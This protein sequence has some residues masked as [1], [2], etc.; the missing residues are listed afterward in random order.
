MYGFLQV[1]LIRNNRHFVV[2]LPEPDVQTQVA[3]GPTVSAR[4]PNPAQDVERQR[5]SELNAAFAAS[6]EPT[7]TDI[8]SP[9]CVV[10]IPSLSVDQEIL[11]KVNGYVYYEER[12]LCL[13]MYL[14]MPLTHIVYVT[15]MRIDPVIVD[16]YLHLLPGI[17]GY[18]A[19]QRLTLLSCDDPSS[20]PLTQKIL[21]RPLLMQRIRESIPHNYP[22]YISCF[23]M[24]P[25]ER[26]LAVRLGLPV[27]GCDP[28]LLHLGSK[29]GSRKLLRR[30]GLPVPDGFE[31][32]RDEQDIAEALWALKRQH[33]GLRR[34][35]VKLNDGFSGDGNAVVNLNEVHAV[36]ELRQQL[37]VLLQPVATDLSYEAFVQK[38][39]TMGGIA[40]AFIEGNEKRSPSVQCR[41]LPTRQ[42]EVVST[43]D[44]VLGGMDHQVFLGAYFPAHPDY[45]RDVGIMGKRVAEGLRDA[46]VW[47]RFSLD[48]VSVRTAEGWKHYALELNLRKG[49]TTHPMLMLMG[50]TRGEYDADAGAYYTANGQKRF[51]FSSDNV[52]SEWFRGLTSHDLIHLAIFNRLQYDGSLQQGVMFH[53]IGALSQFGKLGLVCIGDSAQRAEA[54]RRLTMKVLLREGRQVNGFHPPAS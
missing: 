27:F 5:F 12:L 43:H 47:G 36:S 15:S 48:F 14:R 41:I 44:Q 50:L 9:K 30:C 6:F 46:G 32:L 24:S 49:G 16:Y 39:R 37:P 10:I 4:S 22:A 3:P 35:V 2:N 29:S 13:L 53:L 11:S 33:P 51:Y 40:E 20:K 17:T 28:D 7:F 31:D 26:T 42:I 8:S 18:H 21:E 19:R 45:A 54:Y 23:N 25:L 1:S 52:Q 38:F 34:A